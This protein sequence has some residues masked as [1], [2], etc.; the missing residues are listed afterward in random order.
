MK[1]LE[2]AFSEDEMDM[3]KVAVWHY[4]DH[5]RGAHFELTRGRKSGFD[6]DILNC[7]HQI[8]KFNNLKRRLFNATRAKRYVREAGSV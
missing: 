6:N 5:Y 3:L 4:E 2:I 7:R 8:R 1:K